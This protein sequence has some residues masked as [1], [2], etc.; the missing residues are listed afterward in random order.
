M[1]QAELARRLEVSVPTISNLENGKGTSLDIFVKVVF[2]LGLQNELQDLFN[3]PALTIA[4]MQR[5]AA[6]ST[7]QR[8]RAKP[9][10]QQK[11]Q[12]KPKPQPAPQPGDF[13]PIPT[14]T[15]LSSSSPSRAKL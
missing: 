6:V 2:A 10:P 7:R 4:E 3:K 9:K 8:A 15:R 13:K 12:Q 5:L 1:T 14:V 11:P